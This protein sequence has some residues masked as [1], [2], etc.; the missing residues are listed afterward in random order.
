MNSE[1]NKSLRH[2]DSVFHMCHAGGVVASWS[3]AQEVTGLNTHFLQKYFPSSTDSVHSTEFNQDKTQDNTSNQLNNFTA[4][5]TH[6]HSAHRS[7]SIQTNLNAK[8]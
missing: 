8:L 3:L 4:R 7:F 1:S 6:T 5:K 2:K